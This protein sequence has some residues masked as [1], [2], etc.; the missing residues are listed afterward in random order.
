MSCPTRVVLPCWS[1]MQGLLPSPP[2]PVLAVVLLPSRQPSVAELQEQAVAMR[3]QSAAANISQGEIDL[4][5][6]TPAHILQRLPQGARGLP[7]VHAEGERNVVRQSLNERQA[8]QR[9]ERIGLRRRE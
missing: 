3:D 8:R 6:G 7:G 2:H 5:A 9:A 1:S 4:V